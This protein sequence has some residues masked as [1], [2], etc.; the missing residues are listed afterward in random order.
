MALIFKKFKQVED[1]YHMPCREICKGG[2]HLL[3]TSDF[4]DLLKSPQLVKFLQGDSV[5]TV[6]PCT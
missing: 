3:K 5:L 2:I 1:L 4:T 6:S